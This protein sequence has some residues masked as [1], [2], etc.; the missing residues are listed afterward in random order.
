MSDYRVWNES[1]LEVC[2]GILRLFYGKLWRSILDRLDHRFDGY[3]RSLYCWGE[4]FR[5]YRDLPAARGLEPAP[6]RVPFPP[7]E[8]QRRRRAL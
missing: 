6:S 4:E 1:G 7:G 5:I 8:A 2:T 3:L